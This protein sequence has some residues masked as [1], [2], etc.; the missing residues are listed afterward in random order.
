M[1]KSAILS[2]LAAE[3][4][5]G[6][7]IFSTSATVAIRIK[8]KLEDP[9]CSLDSVVRLIQAEPLLSTKVVAIAN[10]V[11][12]NRS[13]KKIADVR[14]AITLIGM[15]TVR[16]LA[17]AVVVQQLVGVQ[18]KNEQVDQL[19]KHSAYMAA[20]AQIIARR[21]TGQDP[22]TAMFAGM[23]HEIG[24]FYLLA[25]EKYYPGLIDESMASSWCGDED[26]D[27]ESALDCEITI[28]TAVLK[29]LSVPEVVL[30]N[31]VY[32]WQGHLTF[33]P[34]S[35]GDTLLI[36]NQLAPVKSPFALPSNQQGSDV[37]VSSALLT[38]DAALSNVLQ[39]SEEEVRVLT[40]AL[41]A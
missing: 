21:V 10:S 8:E 16:N 26:L 19:W 33:P 28:G 38:N 4:E 27:A 15:R 22:E 13:G 37:D 3:V 1:E 31:I 40:E 14:S 24:W 25:R 30:E 32:L 34:R 11:L 36:A 18:V 9:D 23:I 20:L 41:C 6:R 35:L 17:T 12:F 39:D 2:V 29:A 7:L 5:Q